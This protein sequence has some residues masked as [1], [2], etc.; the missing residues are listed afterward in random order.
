MRE[1]GVQRLVTQGRTE[2][3]FARL[4]GS[5][6]RTVAARAGHTLRKVDRAAR[7]E[8]ARWAK[9]HAPADRRSAA[10]TSAYLPKRGCPTGPAQGSPSM[11]ALTRAT[12]AAAWGVAAASIVA[13][14]ATGRAAAGAR[15]GMGPAPRCAILPTGLPRS[16]RPG[17]G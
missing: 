17:I 3:E 6:E 1:R 5:A 8:A 7:V 15:I 10:S 12:M 11:I 14:G 9:D 2:S 13:A 4:L 16:R